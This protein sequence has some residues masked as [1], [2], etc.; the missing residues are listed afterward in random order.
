MEKMTLVEAL[1]KKV[2]L[3][4]RIHSRIRTT[5]FV[6]WHKHNE[7]RTA[8]KKQKVAEFE[9]DAR[10]SYQSI[11]DLIAYYD[12]LNE[13]IS[14]ANAENKIETSIGEMSIAGVIARKDQ[15]S[16]KVENMGILIDDDEINGNIDLEQTLARQLETQLAYALKKVNEQNQKNNTSAEMMRNSIL[17]RENK[18]KEDSAVTSVVEAYLSENKAELIDPIGA[19]A[20][21]KKLREENEK[22]LMELN[23]KLKIA[24]ATVE[25]EI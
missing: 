2:L 17:G 13:A 4:K 11:M 8:R 7:L 9:A 20:Q 18:G 10:A 16:R 15:L 3:Q 6:E 19:E 5:G 1:D 12:K 23:V 24:N 21:S 14:K 22:L 25:I